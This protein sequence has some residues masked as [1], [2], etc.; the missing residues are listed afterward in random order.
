LFFSDV[1]TRT[2]RQLL[3]LKRLGR[4][5]LASLLDRGDA[6]DNARWKALTDDQIWGAMEQQ[7]FPS[8]SRASYSDWYD[9]TFWAESITKVAPQL[10]AVLDAAD[11][12]GPGD[13]TK[14]PKFMAERAAL[15]KSVAEVTRNTK[16]AF[17]KG[18]PVAV[19]FALAGGQVPAS[20]AAQ[21]DGQKQF[22]KQS[23]KVL[24]A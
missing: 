9:I 23:S 16:A 15:A 24:R 5:V 10:K 7:K 17:E 4:Q 12:L 3:D 13:P 18:W 6:V 22:E 1:S 21:W 2:A 11:K 19:M 14:D 20:F 8:G